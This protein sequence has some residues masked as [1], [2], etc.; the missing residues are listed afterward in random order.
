MGYC[1]LFEAAKPVA[2]SNLRTD[3]STH[4]INN[5]S[6]CQPAQMALAI[7][8]N[9]IFGVADGLRD[10]V[11]QFERG[12]HLRDFPDRLSDVVLGNESRQLTEENGQDFLLGNLCDR[13]ADARRHPLPSSSDEYFLRRTD[14]SMAADN[15]VV[16]NL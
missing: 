3:R 5:G 6:A 10:I 11:Q 8:Q 9:R 4:S 12:A 1:L 13:S 14:S 16:E 15:H 2:I 7:F